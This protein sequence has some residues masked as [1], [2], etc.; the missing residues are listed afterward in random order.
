MRATAFEQQNNMRSNRMVTWNGRTQTVCEWAH[1]L[2]LNTSTLA[3]R[4]S[5]GWTVEKALWS[6]PKKGN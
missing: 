3:K 5:R 6:Q 4:L 1:E 2:K